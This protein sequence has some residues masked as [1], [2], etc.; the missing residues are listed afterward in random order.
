M[1]S[2]T[3]GESSSRRKRP[4]N[5]H[6]CMLIGSEVYS[7]VTL[8]TF[9]KTNSMAIVTTGMHSSHKKHLFRFKAPAR[10]LEKRYPTVSKSKETR[11]EHPICYKMIRDEMTSF[12]FPTTLNYYT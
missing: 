7:I 11:T 8:R 2:R 1:S 5:G 12:S 10:A 6:L 9:G 3:I 4:K